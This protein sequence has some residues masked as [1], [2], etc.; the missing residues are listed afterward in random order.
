[1][2]R[3]KQ[4]QR[5]R[6]GSIPRLPVDVV[7]VIAAEVDLLVDQAFYFW[8]SIMYNYNLWQIMAINCKLS[9]NHFGL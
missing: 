7:A 9:S 8:E 5:K 1:M 2:A 3:L 6:V 4:T